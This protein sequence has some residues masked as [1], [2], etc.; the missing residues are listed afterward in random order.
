MGNDCYVRK[1]QVSSFYIEMYLYY[2]TYL[3]G[4]VDVISV[5]L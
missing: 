2:G 3:I 5:F 1:S 4:F